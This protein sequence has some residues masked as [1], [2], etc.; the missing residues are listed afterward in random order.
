MLRST[1]SANASCS[2]ASFSTPSGF[3]SSSRI[4][5]C[6][7]SHTAVMQ[8]SEYRLLMPSL[9]KNVCATGAGSARPVVSMMTPSNLVT[10]VASLRSVSTRSLRTVQQ[11]QPFITSM[12]SSSIFSL[13]CVLMIFSSMPTSPNSFSMMANRMPWSPVSR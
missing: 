9:M 12:I 4:S 7:A 8:S 13:I 6:F 3:S 5:K 1:R 11:R 2:T 10:F